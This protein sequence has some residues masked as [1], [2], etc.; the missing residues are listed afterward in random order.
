MIDIIGAYQASLFG[1]FDDIVPSADTIPVFLEMFRDKG[2]LPNIF[3]EIGYETRSRL[4][5][6]STD[7]E[8][9]VSFGAG[10]IMIEKF[11]ITPKGGNMGTVDGFAKDVV[12]FFNRVLVKFPKKGS[13]LSLVTSGLL[14]EMPEAKLKSIYESLVIPNKFYEK[15]HPV[16]WNIRS[17]ANISEQISGINEKINAITMINR[18]QGQ[19]AN[20]DGFLAFDRIEVGFDINTFQ[21]NLESRFDSA[22]ISDFYIKAVD[23]RGSLFNELKEHLDV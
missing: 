20:P 2:F 18:L 21:G 8:W 13:R 11:P 17:V 10:R 7:G 22:S 19:M 5:L 23:L 4:R 16:E 12:D 1:T 9:N 6:N 3:Q 15:F 14:K